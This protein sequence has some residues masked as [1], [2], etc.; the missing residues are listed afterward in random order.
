MSCG[1]NDDPTGRAVAKQ[2]AAQIELDIQAGYFD[3]TLLKY[4]PLTRGK[5]ATEISTVELFQK[6]TQYQSKQKCLSPR[7]LEARYKP[8][9]RHLEKSLNI[10]TSKVTENLAGNFVALQLERVSSR[11][12]KERV[13]LLQ[14]CWEFA[15]GKYQIADANPWTVHIPKIKTTETKR[16]KPF[17]TTEIQLIL[18]VAEFSMNQILFK[19]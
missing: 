2:K 5:N 3:P 9:E 17:S 10:T 7:S 13:W 4:K 8:L 14:S 12:A 1:V 15:R 11:T 6:F 18:G 19:G 16:V